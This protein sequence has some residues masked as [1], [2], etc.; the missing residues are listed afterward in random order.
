[1]ESS[2]EKF[3]SARLLLEAQMLPQPQDVRFVI[4]Y[5]ATA[6]ERCAVIVSHISD[7]RKHCIAKQL[8]AKQVELT[9]SNGA[10]ALLDI[11]ACY[12]NMPCGV[13]V[14][15]LR[16]AADISSERA[17]E[18]KDMLNSKCVSTL[19]QMMLLLK[20]ELGVSQ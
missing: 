18:V 13:K 15:S 14:G 11:H 1:M 6:N 9:L 5:I 8:S 20:K 16:G 10:V 12:P 7:V 2:V 17:E 4:S 19:N 3:D